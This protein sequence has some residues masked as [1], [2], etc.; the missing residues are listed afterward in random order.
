[1]NIVVISET[2]IIHE[3]TKKVNLLNGTITYYPLTEISP[4]SF[5]K[6]NLINYIN[7]A[8]KII[9]QS[10][11]A[12]KCTHEIW[13]E[14][15]ITNKQTFYAIGKVTS[16][17]VK[18][19]IGINCEYPV[20]DY[21]S[22]GLLSMDNLQ[23]VEN[24]EI[25][26]IKGREGREVIFKSLQERGAEVKSFDVY[27]RKD[28]SFSS[29]EIPLDDSFYNYIIV[30]SQSSLKVFLN[31][32]KNNL[33]S[34]K[35]VFLVPDPRIIDSHLLGASSE[36]MVVDSID[37]DSAYLDLIKKHQETIS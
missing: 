10:K 1:M 20:N 27:E 5:N 22:H 14:T 24:Q 17:C 12:V 30:L 9:F 15:K 11:N 4:I 8:D 36:F 37:N 28:K 29:N 35:L 33:D 31:K 3:L 32:F 13:K 6:K 18:E 34:Y 23:R 16:Q 19:E 7:K 2:S 25:I 26:I 21:S